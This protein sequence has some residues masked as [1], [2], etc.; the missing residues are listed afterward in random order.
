MMKTAL[1]YASKYGTTEKIAS[2]IAEKL[3][4]TNDIELFC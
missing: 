3:K 4:N 1:I 2:S